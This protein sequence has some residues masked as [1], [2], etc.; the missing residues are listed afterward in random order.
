M[1][2]TCS[3]GMP[4]AAPREETSTLRVVSWNGVEAPYMLFS[5]T[6]TTGSFFTA[7]KLTPSWKAPS[8]TAPSPKKHATTL[9]VPCCLS[10][11]ARPGARVT[12]PPTMAIEGRMPRSGSPRCIDPPRPPRQPASRP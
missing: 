12:P 5:Q 11:M 4:Y 9:S 8:L 10:A 6:K 2:S 1:P 7:A 3:D